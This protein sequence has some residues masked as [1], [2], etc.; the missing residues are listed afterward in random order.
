MA[1]AVTRLVLIG[2]PGAETAEVAG[3]LA[4]GLGL[5]LISMRDA[6]QSGMRAGS[7]LR[8]DLRRFMGAE[9]VPP[10]E[11]VAAIV[12]RRLGE[13][14]VV[15]G[16]V[17]W[18]ES[19]VLPVLRSLETLMIQMVELVLSDAEATRRLT[20]RRLCRGCGEVWHVESSPTLV[21]GVCD[22]CGSEL[23]HRE[24][25]FPA[26]VAH[27]LSVYHKHSAPV[28]AVYRVAGLLI[29]VDATRPTEEIANE[30]T[31]RLAR[32]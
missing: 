3:R 27:Q 26:A 14:D 29:S 22:R 32:S 11:L 15:G 13:P 2:P 20:G 19:P 12:L 28:L 4:G 25:D 23:F 1:L 31:S 16:F 24:D 7:E 21:E 8:D 5:P 30:L 9:Q 10:L 18:T 6:V 17:W